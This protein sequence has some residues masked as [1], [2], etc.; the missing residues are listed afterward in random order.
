MTIEVKDLDEKYALIRDYCNKISTGLDPL[1][2]TGTM[3]SPQRL[4]THA[5]RIIEIFD[6]IEKEVKPRSQ[7]KTV[8]ADVLNMFSID[9]GDK[10]MS[11]DE[12][13]AIIEDRQKALDAIQT[14]K[15][16]LPPKGTKIT[17]E[18]AAP[19]NFDLKIGNGLT[20]DLPVHQ[21]YGD[22]VNSLSEQTKIDAKRKEDRATYKVYAY[23]QAEILN[24]KLTE[25]HKNEDNDDSLFKFRDMNKE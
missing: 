15:F 2:L 9:L 14:V 21:L 16:D 7:V 20:Q 1:P 10:K 17:F 13:N 22:F 24:K 3:I 4:R 12:A 6:S 5:Q 19:M 23:K 25:K 8:P 18:D 11:I